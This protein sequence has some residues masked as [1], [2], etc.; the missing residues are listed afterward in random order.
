MV[1]VLLLIE[2]FPTLRVGV[3]IDI[4]ATNT[5]HTYNLLVLHF[6]HNNGFGAV[7]FNLKDKLRKALCQ[8]ID[9]YSNIILLCQLLAASNF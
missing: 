6:S 7:Q 1:S 9:S 3:S 2:P 8:F 4:V 5:E